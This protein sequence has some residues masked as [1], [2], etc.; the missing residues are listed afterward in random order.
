MFFSDVLTTALSLFLSLSYSFVPFAFPLSK[1]LLVILFS[2]A[3]I[4]VSSISEH[5]NDTPPKKM[6]GVTPVQMVT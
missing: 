2:S 1:R 4:E 6:F 3:S 5:I